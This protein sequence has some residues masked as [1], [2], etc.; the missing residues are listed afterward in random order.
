MTVSQGPP[1]VAASPCIL[2]ASSSSASSSSSSSSSVSAG[3]QWYLPETDALYQEEIRLI[4]HVGHVTKAVSHEVLCAL[5]LESVLVLLCLQNALVDAKFYARPFAIC[6]TYVMSD[7]SGKFSTIYIGP[8]CCVRSACLH[9]WARGQQ[10]FHDLTSEALI[11][12]Q[13]SACITKH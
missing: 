10:P 5:C 11:V 2:L 13:L 6:L 7:F 4:I 1:V 12:K 8:S 9:A 3:D